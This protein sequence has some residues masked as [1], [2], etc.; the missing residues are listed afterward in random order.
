[1]DIIVSN[2]PN[3]GVVGGELEGAAFLVEVTIQL[4]GGIVL[5]DR[6]AVFHRRLVGL[7]NVRL[8]QH[9]RGGQGSEQEWRQ[10]RITRNLVLVAR[11][12]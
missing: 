11:L 1:M 9:H 4:V 7:L 10:R 3:G 12:R 2:V 8:K 5:A 6:N